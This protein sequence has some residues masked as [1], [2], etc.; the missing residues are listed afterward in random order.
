[1]SELCVSRRH[2]LREPIC[3][4]FAL[5][6]HPTS[7]ITIS[8]SSSLPSQSQ[9]YRELKRHSVERTWRH[10]VVESKESEHT[11]TRARYRYRYLDR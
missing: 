5:F 9:C 1:M 4:F 11:F 8:V 7:R 6:L 10:D 2:I 3:P